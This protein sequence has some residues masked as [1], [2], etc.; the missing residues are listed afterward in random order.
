[1]T[2]GSLRTD[3][4]GE[5]VTHHTA[6][7]SSARI[8][9][10]QIGIGRAAV[11][12]GLFPTDPK[13][14]RHENLTIQF[15]NGP[16]VKGVGWFNGNGESRDKPTSK[17][18]SGRL[19]FAHSSKTLGVL[20]AEGHVWEDVVF[21]IEKIHGKPEGS[22]FRFHSPQPPQH[23]MAAGTSHPEQSTEAGQMVRRAQVPFCNRVSEGTP[24]LRQCTR[25][26]PSK[27]LV[28]RSDHKPH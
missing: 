11:D 26:P 13:T 2:R 27:I 22:H 4:A 17:N 9:K 25:R 24:M 10:N 15:D 1:M 23:A 12:A 14:G 19:M 6:K 18:I 5:M 21:T 3:G 7:I 28:Q 8:K 20:V 16:L